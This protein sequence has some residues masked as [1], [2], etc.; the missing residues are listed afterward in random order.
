MRKTLSGLIVFGLLLVPIQ[1]LNAATIKAGSTCPKLGQNQNAN[2]LKYT[3]IKSG[4]KLVW[5]KGVVITKPTPTPSPTPTPTPS[6]TPTPNPTPSLSPTP[7]P[8]KR[9]L[10]GL[11]EQDYIGYFEDNSN[12]FNTV[13]QNSLAAQE[14]NFQKGFD[15]KNEFSKQWS[16]YLIPNE[17]GKWSIKATSDD[18]SYIWLGKNA[19]SQSIA[20]NPII[21]LAGIH[22]PLTA[23]I[24]IYLV[25][26]TAYPI[27]IIYGN[28][29]N[30]S[31]MTLTLISPS[32]KNYSSLTSLTKFE[33]PAQP[34]LVGN[35]QNLT[36][37]ESDNK[38]IP[39][40]LDIWK[41]APR[42]STAL[43]IQKILDQADSNQ[44][45]FNGSVTWVF[46]GETSPEIEFATKRGLSNGI[47]FY[48]K[49]GFATTSTIAL[50]ARDMNWL[51]SQLTQFSC[52]YG[53]LPAYPGFYVPRTCQSGHG[54]VTA[55]HWEVAKTTD[56][57]DGITFNHVLSHEYFHQLQEELSGNVGN[58]PF[59]L[60]F[61]E[62]G[63][64]F[65]T[66]IAYSSWN[67]DRYYEQWSDYWFGTIWPDQKINCISVNIFDLQNS[68]K[69]PNRVCGYS[70]GSLVVEKFIADFGIEKYK[71]II[72][73]IANTPSKNFDQAFKEVTGTDLQAFYD[74]TQIF[75]KLRGWA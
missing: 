61:W 17:T 7:T 42:D 21:N 10:D 19:F 9:F 53:E 36:S 72:R 15:G 27:R 30:F 5:N 11:Y 60:W 75:L 48:T 22:G 57:L 40:S 49:L 63:A 32:D 8:I 43:A 35:N 29:I 67:K 23:Q 37:I 69:G 31:Q 12:L 25:K 24:S 16:G 39:V 51:K 44:S 20:P 66:L 70:K 64:H 13:P 6:P 18:A 14:I 33:N 3:C 73:L 52:T 68:E 45:V 4:K 41:N 56:G 28:S 2:G 34:N 50:N 46:Q 74:E 54:A 71:E 38:I 62:G 55:Q 26:D 58:G 1:F 47:A 65:F 59:P